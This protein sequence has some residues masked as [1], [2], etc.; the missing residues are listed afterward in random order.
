[1]T[2]YRRGVGVKRYSPGPTPLG[3]E[4]TKAYEFKV[5]EFRVGDVP[6][7][8]FPPE[9][10]RDHYPHCFLAW[11]SLYGGRLH[12][13]GIWF[14]TS[15]I[16]VE[17][18]LPGRGRELLKVY[19][20]AMDKNAAWFYNAGSSLMIYLDG[21]KAW[22]SGP[23][24]SSVDSWNNKE[25]PLNV[26][27]GTAKKLELRIWQ[28]A[29]VYVTGSVYRHVAGWDGGPI[30]LTARY[31]TD[32]PPPMADVYVRVLDRYRASPIRGAYV[33]LKV[34]DV[35]KADGFTDSDGRVAFYN[36]EAGDYVL[37]ASKDGY[38]EVAEKITV[39]PP[40]VE[41]TVYLT[42]VPAKPF[43][44]EWVAVGAA[45]VGCGGILMALARRALAK[46]GPRRGR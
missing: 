12:T 13:E 20:A 1:M 9:E 22:D 17:S 15:P 28:K 43:P 42:P 10:C 19:A 16:D 14:M 37:R 39:A 35:V 36:I 5:T 25:W 34:G 32:E 45:V 46:R 31:F 23:M 2:V 11:A 3:Y 24:P 33:A 27:L 6:P 44:W 29:A 26:K 4:R 21:A 38:H 18:W 8:A 7:L 41:R 40:K 30:V